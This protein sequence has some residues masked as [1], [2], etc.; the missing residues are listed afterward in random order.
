MASKDTECLSG[1]S[2]PRS[3]GKDQGVHS[4]VDGRSLRRAW[5]AIE[6]MNPPASTA[7]T[8]QSG[9]IWRTGGAIST[10]VNGMTGFWSPAG[11]ARK[12]TRLMLHDRWL[13]LKPLLFCRWPLRASS[14]PRSPVEINRA[15]GL[16]FLQQTRSDSNATLNACSPAYSMLCGRKARQ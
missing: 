10:T 1:P 6:R 9:R 7:S 3:D 13:A 15:S 4:V 8:R 12:A 2:R 5:T 11:L 16:P 14:E